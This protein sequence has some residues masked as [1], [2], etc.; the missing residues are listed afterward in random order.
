MKKL[1]CFS[2]VVLLAITLTG[3]TFAGQIGIPGEPPPPASSPSTISDDIATPRQVNTEPC[4]AS[5]D[6]ATEFLLSIWRIVMLSVF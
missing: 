6:S 3:T 5:N 4:E 1:R 2:L